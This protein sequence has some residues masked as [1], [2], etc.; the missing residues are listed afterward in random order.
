MR[1]GKMD[2]LKIRPTCKM[3]GLKNPSYVFRATILET[4]IIA[5]QSLRTI[6][7]IGNKIMARFQTK[8]VV[9]MRYSD[10][11]SEGNA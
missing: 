11:P 5:N 10:I 2:G 4:E 7:S 6:F 1:P 8:N 3:D 9:I